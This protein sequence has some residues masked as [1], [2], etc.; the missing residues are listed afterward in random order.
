MV[1]V[2][3]DFLLRL[4]TRLNHPRSSRELHPDPID[5]DIDH[6]VSGLAHI[7]KYINPVGVTAFRGLGNGLPELTMTSRFYPAR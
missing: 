7:G 4:L 5:L 2:V 3:R 1:A 6:V